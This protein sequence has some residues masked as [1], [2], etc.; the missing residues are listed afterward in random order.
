MSHNLVSLNILASDSAL[1]T[2]IREKLQAE[3]VNSTCLTISACKLL[4]IVNFDGCELGW[5][6]I[7]WQL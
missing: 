5:F 3:V 2:N 4:Q 1:E 7:F 6:D